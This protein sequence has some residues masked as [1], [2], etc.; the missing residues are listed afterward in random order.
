M[1]AKYEASIAGRGFILG[2]H[3]HLG[4]TNRGLT[5]FHGP[6]IL[7]NICNTISWIYTILW[8]LVQYDTMSDLIILVDH[9]DLYFMVQ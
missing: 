1:Y 7:L 4:K 9:C 2:I 8:I 3:L 6:L 5:I